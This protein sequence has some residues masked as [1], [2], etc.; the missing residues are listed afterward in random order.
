MPF[1]NVIKK[2]AF[3]CSQGAEFMFMIVMQATKTAAQTST[4]PTIYTIITTVTAIIGAV[5]GTTGFILSLLNFRRD[6]PQVEPAFKG[7]LTGGSNHPGEWVHLWIANIGRRPV[8]ILNVGF[9]MPW[10]PRVYHELNGKKQRITH[11][12]LNGDRLIP[13]TVPLRQPV[14]HMVFGGKGAETWPLREGDRPLQFVLPQRAFAP[15]RAA[16]NGMK[17]FACDSG[18]KMHIGQGPLGRQPDWAD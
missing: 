1:G 7:A 17:A 6:N 16:W 15:Y 5:L 8:H 14:D 12:I 10:F 18:G 11:L 2:S 13:A 4:E 3:G 9:K